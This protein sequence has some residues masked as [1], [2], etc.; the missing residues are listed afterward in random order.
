M[1]KCIY[2]FVL[3]LT[4]CSC[5][6]FGVFE[7]DSIVKSTTQPYVLCFLSPQ[8]TVIQV[9][10]KMTT[11]TVG[12]GSGTSNQ[13]ISN[14]RVVLRNEQNQEIIL[15]WNEQLKKYISS[16]NF[17]KIEAQKQYRLLVTT[18][19]GDSVSASCIIPS[20]ID[21][22]TV[23]VTRATFNLENPMASLPYYLRWKDIGNEK[24]Y[25]A[26]FGLNY[27]TDTLEHKTYLTGVD[28]QRTISDDNIQNGIIEYPIVGGIYPYKRLEKS[29]TG[30]F[31]FYICQTDEHYYRYHKEFSQIN[32]LSSSEPMKLYSNMIGG[33]GV[34]AGYNGVMLRADK[35]YE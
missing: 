26:A 16:K 6:N 13:Y 19:K 10:V 1:K 22:N 20:T 3:L 4:M 2:L 29:H 30:N 7:E 34:F 33:Y 15:Q 25:Y 28:A 35:W 32:D 27:E 17:F 5:E 9:T 24:N 18:L 23:S 8:D 31:M 21:S 12:E 11:P 14:A